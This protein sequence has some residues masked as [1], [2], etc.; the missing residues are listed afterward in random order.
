MYQL[1]GVVSCDSSFF[2]DLLDK[3]LEKEGK[4]QVKTLS[5]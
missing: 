5:K 1:E 2:I 3:T 4:K